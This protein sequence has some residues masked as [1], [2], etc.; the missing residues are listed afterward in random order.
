MEAEV[1]YDYL[2]IAE[3][4]LTLETV[5]KTVFI[6]ESDTEDKFLFLRYSQTVSG[7]KLENQIQFG[8]SNITDLHFFSSLLNQWDWGLIETD[9]REWFSRWYK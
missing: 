5:F 7:N 8:I 3:P 1:D 6:S 9:F 2:W 4:N